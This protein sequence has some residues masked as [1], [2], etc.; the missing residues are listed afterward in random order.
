MAPGKATQIGPSHKGAI[1][2]AM[3]IVF[4]GEGVWRVMFVI[5]NDVFA[6]GV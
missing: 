3:N 4:M 5:Y 2:R 1:I 6:A